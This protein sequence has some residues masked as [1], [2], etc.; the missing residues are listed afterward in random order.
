MPYGDILGQ[1]ACLSVLR[2]SLARG[3]IAHAYLF[4]GIEGCGK[5]KCALAFIEAL[6]C[7]RDEGCS[8]CPSCR[9]LARF[10]HPDLHTVEPDGAFIKID[11]IRELQKDLSLRPYE[12]PRKACI[13][14]SVDR[15][16]PA[17]GNALLKTLEEPPGDAL[18]ILL[19]AQVG[20]VLPTILSRCQRLRFPALP[21]PAVEQF[22]LGRGITPETARTA[23]SLAEGSMKKALEISEE[24]ALA[25]R[26]ALLSRLDM[27][28]V[29]EMA[30]LFAAAEELGGNREKAQEALDLLT[31][32]LRDI[33]LMQGGSQELVNRD[34]ADL[35]ERNAARFSPEKTMER[36]ESVLEARN[37]LQRNVNPRLALE[38]LFMRL[39][40]H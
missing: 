3:K 19:T 16:N 38:V 20:S 9:K 30:P 31:A 33:M 27:L 13:I 29:R 36:I 8:Q 11:Q 5:N 40:E 10:Q 37:A 39:A 15:L 25:D 22:L 7:G 18:I 26:K 1:E 21:Q 12:A 17:A 32:Y 28:T 34:L 14:D 2:R 35:I 4:E 24:E 23:A 6:F